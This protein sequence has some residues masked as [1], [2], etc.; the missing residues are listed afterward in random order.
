MKSLL[1]CV[2]SSNYESEFV[3]RIESILA[4][5]LGSCSVR[6]VSAGGGF[7]CGDF[8]RLCEDARSEGYRRIFIQPST[9]AFSDGR[10][11]KLKGCIE[12]VRQSIPEME[13]TVFP[14]EQ[15]FET[16][17]DM[18]ERNIY[19]ASLTDT[20]F[21]ET[22]P[23]EIQERSFSFISGRLA[24]TY[25]D[26]DI[27]SVVVRIIHSTADFGVERLLHFSPDAV[28]KGKEALQSGCRVITDVGMVT[29]GL[30]T[31]FR[32]RTVSAINREGVAECAQKKGITRSA[33]GIELLAERL[34]GAVAAIGN[35]PTALVHLLTVINRT[36]MRPACIVGVPV[37][38]VGAAE[39]KELLMASNL[40]YICIKGNRGGTPVAVAAVNAMGCLK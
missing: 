8:Q 10:H 26:P 36:G 27:Q 31:R 34:D 23:D 15:L 18:I 17:A 30:A 4:H 32:D 35:A 16:C 12:H 9:L 2:L 25:D 11:Q 1:I 28:A 19:H 24:K 40:P 7:S 14:T 37:G 39:S 22:P 38:F 29:A 20:P 21:A 6:T 13:F 3:Q 33:A 5:R